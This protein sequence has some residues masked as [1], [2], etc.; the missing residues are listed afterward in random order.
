[1]TLGIYCAGGL[2]RE[3]LMLAMQINDIYKLWTDI[4]FI[5]DVTKEKYIKNKRVVVF[6][7]VLK[8]FKNCQIEIC[9]ANG[10]PIYR[11]EIFD[12]VKKE[13]YKLAT[14]IH[15]SVYISDCTHIGEGSIISSNV[16]ISCDVSIKENVYIQPYV[17]IG[18]DT[19]IEKHSLISTFTTIAGFCVIE[20]MVYIA[21][22]T[23]I[24]DRIKIGKNTIVGMGAVVFKDISEK[25]VAIGNPARPIRINEN[26]KVF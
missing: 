25:V 22:G 24:R 12:R 20:E 4:I 15:P 7:E 6:E 19:L 23:A 8:E 11:K 5:D 17:S 14:L 2:G 9:I 21:P 16:F 18:H 13:G 1:M 3:V 26:G 10:E